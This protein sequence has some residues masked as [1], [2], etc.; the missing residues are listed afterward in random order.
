MKVSLFFLSLFLVV[1]NVQPSFSQN[2][3]SGKVTDGQTPIQGVSVLVDGTNNG[4]STDA[5]GEYTINASPKDILVFS[6]VGM[7]SMEIVVE[8]VTEVLN[9]VLYPK[10]EELE[11]VTISGRKRKSQQEFARNYFSDPTIINTNVGYLSPD[12][13]AWHLRV[14]DGRELNPNDYDI[15]EAIANKISGTVIRSKRGVKHLFPSSFGSM[16]PGAVGVNFEVDGN[17][18]Y[19]YNPPLHLD[20]DKVIRVALI[21]PDDAIRLFGANFGGPGVV[22][23]NTS[24]IMQG[25][26]EDG[27]RPYDQVRLRNN[28][29]TGDA[30]DEI[31]VLRNGPTYLKELY[32]STDSD[33]AHEVYKKYVPTFGS[34]YAFV[35]DTYRCL[36]D[37]FGDEKLAN[38]VLGNHTKLFTENLLAMKALAYTYQENGELKKA[39]ELYKKLFVKRPNYVQSYLDLAASYREIGA[40][41]K[42]AAIFTRLD[43]LQ[44]QDYFTMSDTMTVAKL[45][46]REF[47][48]LLALKGERILSKKEQ[49]NLEDLDTDFKGTRLVFEWN[50]GEAEFELQFVNPEGRYYKTEHSLFADGDVIREQ[51]LLGYNTEEFLIDGSMPGTWQVNLKYLGNKRLTPSYL[52]AVVYYNYGTAAQRKETKVFKM[53]FKDVNRELLTLKV[54]SSLITN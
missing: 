41:K 6:Y 49:K 14:V 2:T 30:L 1:L 3:I 44:N 45:V 28:L 7:Q 48:N 39:N 33:S 36:L 32:A 26:T 24:N 42:A 31:A 35:L 22:V 37:K 51:K 34:S 10:V 5:R 15:L 29:Y 21:Y 54:P 13:V 4:T 47:N 38:E 16:G 53:G 52:K 12:L 46:E 23:I 18:W 27:N 11:E 9:I 20:I 50:D 8:D 17:M 25:S 19:N 40:D 43:Y